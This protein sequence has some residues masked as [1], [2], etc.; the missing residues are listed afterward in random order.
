MPRRSLASR[1]E[2][3]ATAAGDRK[4]SNCGRYFSTRAGG[5]TRHADEC[6]RRV[7]TESQ[8]TGLRE[9]LTTL[10]MGKSRTKVSVVACSLWMHEERR[11]DNLRK[12]SQDQEEEQLRRRQVSTW[13]ERESLD[14]GV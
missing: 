6:Q 12:L 5:F 7:E 2:E 1:A 10:E 14:T 3:G 8:L 11:R 13:N 4:C 9:R